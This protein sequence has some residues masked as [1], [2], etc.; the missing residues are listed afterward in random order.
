MHADNLKIEVIVPNHTRYLSL[1]GCVGEVVAKELASY[2]G[3]PETLAYHLNLVLTEAV[4]NAIE[5]SFSEDP[6]LKVRVTIQV[7][8][9]TLCIKVHDHGQGFD[10]NAVP[11][12]D[13]DHP[14]E[15]GFGLYFIKTLMDSVCYRRLK[16]GNVL[17]MRKRLS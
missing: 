1:V 16:H 5:H 17:E 8:E 12:P 14:G 4:N 2:S 9:G 13:L 11:L 7:K 3:N 15:G 10:L 6:E